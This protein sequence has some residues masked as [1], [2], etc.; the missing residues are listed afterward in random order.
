MNWACPLKDVLC[1]CPLS[2]SILRP[3]VLN[4]TLSYIWW[5]LYLPT[6]LLS[7]GLLTLMY[8]YYR[9]I[10][11]RICF[12]VIHQQNE[13]SIYLYEIMR[14]PW[15]PLSL[16]GFAEAPNIVALQSPLPGCFVKLLY[17][18]ALQSPVHRVFHEVPKLGLCKALCLGT[19]Q[20]ALNWGSAKSLL[21]CFAKPITED[22]HKA[23]YIWWV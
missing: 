6:F 9:I 1:A 15:P 13:K 20:S 12:L 17:L 4:R 10:N 16:L 14:S 7:V 22:L 19:L 18:G 23:A 11:N 21:G 3:G 2:L 5:G 8:I